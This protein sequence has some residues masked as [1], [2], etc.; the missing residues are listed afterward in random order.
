MTLKPWIEQ[1]KRTGTFTVRWRDANGKKYRDSYQ[2]DNK[3]DATRRMHVLINQKQ[4]KALGIFKDIP[5][6]EAADLFMRLYSPRLANE[7]SRRC[8]ESQMNQL[9]VAFGNKTLSTITY[10]DVATFWE[11]QEQLG[12]K[13][14]TIRKRVTLLH[15]LYERFKF[16]NAMVPEIMP[17]QVA[18]P[19]LNPATVAIK[20]LGPRKTSLFF[21]NRKRRVSVEE[22]KVA[23]LWC[24]QNDPE[25]W[26]AIELAIWTALRKSDMKKLTAGN[27]IDIV[28]GKTGSPQMMPIMLRNLPHFGNLS[29]R[30]DILRSAMG[31]LKKDTPL[32]TTW[33][34]LR[35]CAPSWL[36]DGA[37]PDQVISQYLG[38]NDPEMLKI[39]TQ[40]SGV[41]LL[42]AV[43]FIKRKL[44][45]I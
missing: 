29:W 9:R 6:K 12:L 16:W 24:Q 45:A 1:D 19:D 25:L 41:A 23:K 37:F 39:Y 28:Q 34:D 36:A 8:Y 15:G 32:H 11:Q 43:E 13:R 10:Q 7:Q 35:H 27:S 18:L 20:Y 38:H 26:Q 44:E 4:N 2:W 33:H 30:W 21:L 3:R 22:L 40:P 5:F 31:W 42:P 17:D 14:T